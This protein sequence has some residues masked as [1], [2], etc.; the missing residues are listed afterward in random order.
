MGALINQHQ[1]SYKFDSI[2][3]GS[4][5]VL[6]KFRFSATWALEWLAD[7]FVDGTADLGVRQSMKGFPKAVL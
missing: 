5:E 3:G 2:L 7:S 1:S 6:G 4:E